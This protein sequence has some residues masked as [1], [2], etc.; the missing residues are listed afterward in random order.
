MAPH[1][2]ATATELRPL[3][4]A[5]PDRLR[6]AGRAAVDPGYRQLPP[7]RGPHRPPPRQSRTG[8][9]QH[10]VPL[11]R[12][13]ARKHRLHARSGRVPGAC[14]PAGTGSG[15]ARR[16]DDAT[17]A[18]SVPLCAAGR[19]RPGGAVEPDHRSAL[20]ADLARGGAPPGADRRRIRDLHRGLPHRRP[21]QGD[22]QAGDDREDQRHP[23]PAHDPGMHRRRSRGRADRQLGAR[24]HVGD[25]RDPD[26]RGGRARA[27]PWHRRLRAVVR[28]LGWRRRSGC[29][30]GGRRALRLAGDLG[31]S[32]GDG[33]GRRCRRSA[34]RAAPQRTAYVRR[35]DAADG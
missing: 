25:L 30:R 5:R 3:N 4:R 35:A 12:G 7:R 33:R 20:L 6:R 11:A 16:R 2:D 22:R 18:L 13:S 14:A 28:A 9:L 29:S 31:T 26:V 23:H 10:R 21:A 15:A 19:C 32:D 17:P 24:R 8:H 27:A 34:A 1:G